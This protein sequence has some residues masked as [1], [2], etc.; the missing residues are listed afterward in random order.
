V[1]GTIY[2][3][4]FTIGKPNLQSSILNFE[5]RISELN[6]IAFASNYPGTITAEFVNFRQ[7]LWAYWG[8]LLVTLILP[9]HE[10]IYD[11]KTVDSR[12]FPVAIHGHYLAI[13]SL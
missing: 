1:R 10:Q 13:N 6:G 7:L 12:W 11:K 5:S 3:V 4:R 2:E 8:L 9:L